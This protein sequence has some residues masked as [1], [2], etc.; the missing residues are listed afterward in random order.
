MLIPAL[1][2]GSMGIIFGVFLTYFSTKFKTEE[3]PLLAQLYQ[4]LPNANCG[5]CALAGCSSFAEAL[6][7][8]KIEPSKCAMVSEENLQK[9]C[10]LLG[11]KI[12][13]RERYVARVMCYGG[14][15][16]KRRFTYKTIQTCNAVNAL[17]NTTLECNYGCIGMGDCVK[18]CPTNAISMNENNLPVIDEKI[19]IGCGKCVSVCPKNIIKLV[20]E[21]KNIY[22]ACSSNDRAPTVVKV[23]KAGCIGCGRCVKVCPH[24]AIT[25]QNNLAV[26]DYE[27]CDNCGRCVEECPRKIIFNAA[28]KEK[29]TTL[30]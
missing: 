19:C 4:L 21:G 22:I 18:V 11:I 5:A 30:A 2:L 20:P 13:E 23:C 3:N 16:A 1:I 7:Q 17:F 9:I 25:L 29:Q 10:S 27:K 14:N 26:I 8:G 24:E 12:G 15:N 28:L 6:A